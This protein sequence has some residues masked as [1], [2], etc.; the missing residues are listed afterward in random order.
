MSAENV[1]QLAHYTKLRIFGDSRS[2]LAA[3]CAVPV[4]GFIACVI[5]SAVAAAITIAGFVTSL[6]DKGNPNDVNANLAP[7]HPADWARWLRRGYPDGERNLSLSVAFSPEG[8][9]LASALLDKDS[10]ALGC[11]A[12]AGRTV[13]RPGE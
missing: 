4:F 3:V 5:L 6:H 12:G 8:K 7:I 13:A 2:K 11:G 1:R 9:T 10:A